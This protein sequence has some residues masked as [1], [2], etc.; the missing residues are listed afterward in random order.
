[1]CLLR[2]AQLGEPLDG[3]STYLCT[4]AV[5]HGRN[6][7]VSQIL[8][9][10][11]SRNGDRVNLLSCMRIIAICAFSKPA[12]E[13]EV[14]GTRVGHDIAIEQVWDQGGVSSRGE[15]I[16]HELAVLPNAKDVGHV[17]DRAAVGLRVGRAREVRFDALTL[18]GDV[19]AF[20]GAP[21]N[22]LVQASKRYEPCFSDCQSQR[23]APMRA[24]SWLT[25]GEYD[26]QIGR[27]SW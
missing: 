13:V 12:H 22:E 23:P 18:D 27:A 15:V 2:Y 1:M 26:G 20:G 10:L 17:E 4:E 8:E 5:S 3:Q 6:L 21:G 25:R 24:R 7:L 9:G 14:S 19:F 11:N 16:S